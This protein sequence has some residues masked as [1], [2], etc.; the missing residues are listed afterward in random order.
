MKKKQLLISFDTTALN[1]QTPAIAN[2][3][4]NRLYFFAC[5]KLDTK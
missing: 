4:S 5:N 2:N 1:R 3:R